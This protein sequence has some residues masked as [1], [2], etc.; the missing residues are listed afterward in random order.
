MYARLI[1]VP[2][3]TGPLE[4]AQLTAAVTAGTELIHLHR[5][6]RTLL[7]GAHLQPA[8]IALA[9]GRCAFATEALARVD[10]DLASRPLQGGSL[11]RAIRARAS[12]LALTEILDQ[13]AVYFCAGALR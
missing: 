4:R 12:V 10:H 3:S 9:E 8:F 1:A 2:D 5:A 7:V 11:K 13:H 6:A